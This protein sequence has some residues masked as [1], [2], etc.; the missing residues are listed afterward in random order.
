MLLLYRLECVDDLIEDGCQEV[1]DKCSKTCG[2]CEENV[3]PKPTTPKPTSPPKETTRPP[4]TIPTKPPITIPP[5]TGKKNHCTAVVSYSC[6]NYIFLNQRQNNKKIIILIK[7]C[8]S[9]NY[10]SFLLQAISQIEL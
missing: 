8:K 5:N 6:K 10:S 2:V 7:T 4:V 1:L 9:A 3:T